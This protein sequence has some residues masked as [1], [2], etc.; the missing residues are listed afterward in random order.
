MAPSIPPFAELMHI[1]SNEQACCDYLIS[2]GVYWT[3]KA[4]PKC[5]ALMNVERKL[6]QLRC[7]KKLCRKAL[8]LKS[9]SFFSKHKLPT[10]TIMFLGYLW[11]N[12]SPAKSM[13]RMTKCGS[14]T[15]ASFRRYFRQLVSEAVDP[16]EMVIGGV[17]PTS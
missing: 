5:A 10:S 16:E 6:L 11:L 8:S 3:E 1:F 15:V 13:M 9:N 2:K 14:A 7:G 4:C 17:V 12:D